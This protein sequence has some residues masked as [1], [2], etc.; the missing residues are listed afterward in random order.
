[1]LM[2]RHGLTTIPHRLDTAG[3]RTRERLEDDQSDD[4]DRSR[5]LQ[6]D[7]ARRREMPTLSPQRSNCFPI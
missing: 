1:M 5:R 4:R 2:K 3:E 7:G 6:Q